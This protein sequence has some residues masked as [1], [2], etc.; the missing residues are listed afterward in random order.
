MGRQEIETRENCRGLVVRTHGAIPAADM[1]CTIDGVG[2][3]LRETA[4]HSTG[5]VRISRR[6]LRGALYQINASVEGRPCRIQLMGGAASAVERFGRQIDGVLAGEVACLAPSPQDSALAV[7]TPPRPIVRHKA[8]RPLVLTP[9]AASEVMHRMDFA[10]FLFLDADTGQDA[11][12]Y[13]AGGRETRLIRRSRV[14]L[15]SAGPPRIA[16]DLTTA[17][18]VPES[19]AAARLCCNGLPFLFFVDPRT[20]GGRLLYRRYDGYLSVLG[21]A[22]DSPRR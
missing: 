17:A 2:R 21:A 22:D 7:R 14:D 8:I 1:M 3:T 6:N 5:H 11:V 20:A 16:V 13:R 18:M 10:A 4:L 12:V 9:T 15:P 19:I